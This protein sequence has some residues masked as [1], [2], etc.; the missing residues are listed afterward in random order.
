MNFSFLD[1]CLPLVGLV[2]PACSADTQVGSP[3]KTGRRGRPENQQSEEK[4]K[5]SLPVQVIPRQGQ[6]K[7]F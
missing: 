5:R 7:H 2:K 6:K 1:T 4:A 3:A